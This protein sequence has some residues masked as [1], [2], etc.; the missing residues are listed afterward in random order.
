MGRYADFHQ[1]SITDRDGFWAEQARL[2]DWQ[3]RR[4]PARC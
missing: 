4:C 1:R 3:Q 2:I